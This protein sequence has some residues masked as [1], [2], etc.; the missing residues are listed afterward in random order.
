MRSFFLCILCFFT[1][2]SL[3]GQATAAT[4]AAPESRQLVLVTVP[5][6]NGHAAIVTG[7][8]LTQNGWK[9][10]LAPMPARIGKKG[11]AA[12]GAKREG[13]GKSPCGTYALGTVFGRSPTPPAH[14]TMPYRQATKQDFWIDAPESPLY[15]TWVHGEKPQISHE[16]LLL[17]SGQYDLAIVVEYNTQ[18]VVKDMG[19]AIFLHIWSDAQTPTA[20]CVALEKQHVENIIR[21]LD[22]KKAP[23]I[24]LELK[25]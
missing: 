13:D 17:E 12:P 25:K 6:A 18:P 2:L 21:W 24:R 23:E 1:A 15:N 19:S 3:A 20:G 5:D 4:L 10:E 16:N 11:L 8:S 22:P 9:T 14:A 7:L